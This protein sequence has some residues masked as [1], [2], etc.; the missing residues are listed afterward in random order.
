MSKTAAQFAKARASISGTVDNVARKMMLDIDR[1]VVE[2]TPVDTGRARA[3]WIA[4]TGSQSTIETDAADKGGSGTILAAQILHSNAKPFQRMSI[5]N[6]LPYIEALENGHSGQAPR[7]MA[8][9]TV[10]R[11]AG[12]FK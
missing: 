11:V 4:S 12:K 9:L 8:K 5:T 6:N 1:G 2:M 10:Q 7:G 3:N